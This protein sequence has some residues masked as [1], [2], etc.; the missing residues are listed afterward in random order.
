MKNKLLSFCL[1]FLLLASFPLRAE[2]QELDP[3]QPT[4]ISVSLVAKNDRTPMVG[5]ELAVFY[6]ASVEYNTDGKLI[7]LYTDDFADCG[8]QLDDPDVIVKLDAFVTENSIACRKIVTD[9]KGQAVCQDL[10]LGLYFLKQTSD[11][12]G[13]APCTPFLVTVPF[14][15]ADGLVY[16]VNASPKTDVA[17]LIDITVRK[18]WNTDKSIPGSSYVTVQLLRHNTVLDTA[19]L[20]AQNNWQTTYADMPES[21]AYRIVEVNIPKGFA[22]TYSRDGYTFTVTNTRALAQTGQL[23]WPIPVFAL[24]GIVLLMIGF[25]ILRKPGKQDA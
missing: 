6:V 5:A 20:D 18:V 7:Y 22:A 10:P 13:F 4:S 24:A 17:K 12:E 16:H 25:V 19:T 14:E 2:A 8:F 3:D 9:S 11:V 21:D 23:V 1:V 15:T